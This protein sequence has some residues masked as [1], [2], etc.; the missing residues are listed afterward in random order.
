MFADTWVLQLTSES[1][2]IT[3]TE[4]TAGR[5]RQRGETVNI[6]ERSPGVWSMSAVE[7]PIDRVESDD[8][9]MDSGACKG[10]TH[11]FF[12]PPA[13]RPQ[14]RERRESAARSVCRA[15]RVRDTCVE[16]A[17]EHHEYGFWG[18]ESEDERHAAGFRLI[19]PIGVRARSVG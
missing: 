3:F 13:E 19:A 2:P 1:I 8:D 6:H 14:A 12:P 15:C 7:V 10:L 11:L 18:G 17:R 16:F 5:D 9:W 4:G